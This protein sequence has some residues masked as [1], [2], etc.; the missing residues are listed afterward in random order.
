MRAHEPKLLELRHERFSACERI[1]EQALDE[2][3]AE[4]TESRVEGFRCYRHG[5]V[6]AA[7]RALGLHRQSLQKKLRQ[8]GLTR[9]APGD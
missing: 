8:L 4:L 2:L 9:E 6:S 1:T 3:E 5:N 7:A